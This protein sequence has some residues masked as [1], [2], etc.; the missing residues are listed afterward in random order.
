M[1]LCSEQ[2]ITYNLQQ[3]PAPNA[4]AA[5]VGTERGGGGRFGSCEVHPLSQDSQRDA[6]QRRDSSSVLLAAR[7]APNRPQEPVHVMATE[8]WQQFKDDVAQ[9][10]K[11][12]KE[13]KAREKEGKKRKR[14]EE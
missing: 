13:K 3:T 1:G 6:R 14:P 7:A 2:P 11:I 5:V 12:R 9:L 10:E 8:M 4:R